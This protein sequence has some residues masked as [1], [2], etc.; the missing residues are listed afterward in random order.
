MSE[1]CQVKWKKG[2]QI[3]KKEKKKKKK[4]RKENPPRLVTQKAGKRCEG[5]KAK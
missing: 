4:E 3:E 1:K 2:G 5:Q